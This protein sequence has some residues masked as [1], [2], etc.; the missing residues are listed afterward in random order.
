[1]GAFE[2]QHREFIRRLKGKVAQAADQIGKE[3]V[4][5]IRRSISTPA[6]PAS[7]PGT[8]PHKRSEDLR[9]SIRHEVVQANGVVVELKFIADSEHAVYLEE[10]TEKMSPR[11]F[12]R[13]HMERFK[14]RFLVNLKKK[15]DAQSGGA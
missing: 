3:E 10:G 14:K 2:S 7:A 9:D 4:V 8:P 6:P 12:M 13:P 11:P 15:L 1:M 5:N